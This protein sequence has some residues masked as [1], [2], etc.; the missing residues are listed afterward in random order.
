[1]LCVPIRR[2]ARGSP[3]LDLVPA[4]ACAF[5]LFIPLPPAPVCL[6]LAFASYFLAFLGGARGGCYC[7]LLLLLLLCYIRRGA[8]QGRVS[9]FASL[10]RVRFGADA[11][12]GVLAPTQTLR[13]L[14]REG[15]DVNVPP[16]LLLFSSHTVSYAP[17]NTYYWTLYGRIYSFLPHFLRL[18]QV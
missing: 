6:T 2:L 14:V 18:S 7:V 1:M 13:F 8:L 11:G 12:S 5:S 10:E 17:L 3:H 16:A 4:P 9:A 15:G